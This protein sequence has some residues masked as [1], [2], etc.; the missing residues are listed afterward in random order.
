MPPTGVGAV[1]ISP[2]PWNRHLLLSGRKWLQEMQMGLR[3]AS[4]SDAG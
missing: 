4:V 2:A 3:S 1:L